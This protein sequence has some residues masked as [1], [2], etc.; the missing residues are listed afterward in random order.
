M[1]KSPS[2]TTKIKISDAVAPRQTKAAQLRARLAEPGGVALTEMMR[3][4]GWQ[5]H[6]LSAALTGLRKT[7]IV[8]MRNRD[9]GDT[10]Y[11][12]DPAAPALTTDGGVRQGGE[13]GD[14]DLASTEAVPA[15]PPVA[16]GGLPDAAIPDSDK[17]A[18]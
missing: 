18:A 3:L 1:T 14:A 10:I 17:G 15:A 9:G 6:T 4:T 11:A 2:P 8:V 7:G 12:I 5:A 13:T 16:A